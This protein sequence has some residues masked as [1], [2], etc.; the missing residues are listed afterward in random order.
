MDPND[1]KDK[2]YCKSFPAYNDAKTEMLCYCSDGTT[3]HEK[4]GTSTGCPCPK[5]TSVETYF[6]IVLGAMVG[7]VVIAFIIYGVY[8]NVK[9][10]SFTPLLPVSP[11]SASISSTAAGCPYNKMYWDPF[12]QKTICFE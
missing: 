1:W 10:K 7:V 4:D 2:N 12:T 11:P 5:T 3:C 6:F 8:S 9:S